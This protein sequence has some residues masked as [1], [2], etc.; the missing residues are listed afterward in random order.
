M[1]L[2]IRYWFDRLAALLVFLILSP[3]L[4]I[5]ALFIMRD[6]GPV[7]FRQTRVGQNGDLYRVFKFRSMIVDAD[8]YLDDTGA[9]TRDRITPVGRFIR[10]TSIDELPQ[11]L[12]ILLGDM[13]L[14][15]PRPIL[16]MFLPHMNDA[17][18]QRLN[19]LPG[20]TGWA[21]VNGRNMIKWSE[22]FKLDVHYINN[23]SLWL[24]IKIV[25]MTV[26]KILFASDIAT[27][28]NAAQVNDVT[29]RPNPNTPPPS[30]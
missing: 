21:Q 15:G 4:I 27:D 13:A 12:N 10:K 16:P 5:T 24:D 20:I 14:I 23:A 19:G 26:Q 8:N 2:R 25:A 9:P 7:F 6:G 30:T 18:K 3:L 11:F 22:R 17:E 29:N 28:R 1:Y